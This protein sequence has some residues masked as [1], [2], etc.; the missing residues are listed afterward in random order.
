MN[1]LSTSIVQQYL[2]TNFIPHLDKAI[3]N[4][5]QERMIVAN[6]PRVI[7]KNIVDDFLTRTLNNN[8]HNPQ[9]SV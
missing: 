2:T 1:H 4:K 8:S 3:K 6:V 7:A 9:I 5:I